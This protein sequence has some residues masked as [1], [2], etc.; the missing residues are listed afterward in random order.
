MEYHY[1]EQTTQGNDTPDPYFPEIETD[2][3]YPLDHDVCKGKEEIY[4]RYIS[5]FINSVILIDK[6]NI[7][8][9]KPLFYENT[10]DIQKN[11]QQR[12][13]LMKE[14]NKI[15]ENQFKGH[16]FSI[17]SYYR[18]YLG[19]KKD[20]TYDG[21]SDAITT[22]V[23]NTFI[24][25]TKYTTLDDKIFLKNFS[26]GGSVAN[27]YRLTNNQND[28]EYNTYNNLKQIKKCGK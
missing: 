7:N 18:K 20:L 23:G 28:I 17:T 8:I 4:S 12:N 16:I 19:Q 9:N 3:Y 14:Y 24:G 27:F 25:S 10:K 15:I 11:R 1:K 6:P 21:L 2:K 22:Q 26:S 13:W 5:I